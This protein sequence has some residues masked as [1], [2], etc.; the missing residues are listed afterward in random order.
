MGMDL[1]TLEKHLDYFQVCFTVN[2][3]DM[4]ILVSVHK[5]YVP[6]YIDIN[7]GVFLP[8][9]RIHMFRFLVGMAK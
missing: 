4:S 1:W 6:I 5:L 8:G 7:L 2:D 9:H 3:V